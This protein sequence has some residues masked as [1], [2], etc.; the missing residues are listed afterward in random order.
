MVAVVIRSRSATD[1][2]L[3][4]YLW[5]PSYVLCAVALVVA[6][7]KKCLSTLPWFSINLGY[8]VLYVV[9]LPAIQREVAFEWFALISMLGMAILM[10]GMIYEL[11]NKL[12]LYR[13]P[14][15]PVLRWS[16]ALLLLLAAVAAALF[17]P[18]FR[19]QIARATVTLLL[20]GNFVALGLL[21]ALLLVTRTVGVSW[22]SLP[23]GVALG[24]GISAA[25]DVAGSV[26][27]FDQS[28]TFTDV[29]T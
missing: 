4:W 23:A 17:H 15:A 6:F 13:S 20:C 9:V 28:R 27:A 8:V 24:L 7:R 3:W 18:P 22:R 16:G 29:G 21:L 5:L 2:Y 25:G 1:F 26:L 12:I 10:L 19:S 11:A 14:L